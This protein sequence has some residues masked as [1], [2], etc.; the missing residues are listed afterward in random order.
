MGVGRSGVL[1]A[2]E[3][4]DR[5]PPICQQMEVCFAA[6]KSVLGLGETLAKTLMGW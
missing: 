3:K 4:A 6:L 5:C 1:L 2:T